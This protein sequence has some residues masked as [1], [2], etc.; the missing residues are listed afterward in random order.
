[1]SEHVIKVRV[2]SLVK[3]KSTGDIA[4]DKV[5]EDVRGLTGVVI[6]LYET[7]GP[8]AMWSPLT[9]DI[10]WSDGKFMTGFL[11]AALETI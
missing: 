3:Q 2:G 4:L 6:K 9:A 8:L 1:M 11:V 7:T 5:R 10:L